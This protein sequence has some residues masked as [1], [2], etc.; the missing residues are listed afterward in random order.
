MQQNATLWLRFV[1]FFLATSFGGFAAVFLF[2][3]ASIYSIGGDRL[4]LL[5]RRSEGFC[6]A[7]GVRYA[8]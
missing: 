5:P 7:K 1:Y 3:I 4:S 6:R 2:I 8:R